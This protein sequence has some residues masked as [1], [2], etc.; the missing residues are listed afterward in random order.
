MT[1]GLTPWTDDVPLIGT[2]HLLPDPRYVE[3]IGRNHNLESAVADLIDNSVDAG[4]THVLVRIIRDSEMLRALC[5]V[6]DG[7]GINPNQM[8]RAMTIGARRD[9]LHGDLGYFGIGMKAA[10]LGQAEKLTVLSCSDEGVS[11]RVW[12]KERAA[13]DFECGVV[14]ES[15][16]DTEL[17]RDWSPVTSGTGTIVRWDGVRAFPS[18][19]D[20][21]V[22]DRVAENLVL[23]LRQHLGLTFHR[24]IVER[25]LTIAIDVEDVSSTE[26]PTTTEVAPIDPF[27]YASSPVAGYPRTLGGNIG[28]VPMTLECH[29]WST[30]SHLQGFR[31]P[32][33]RPTEFQ[34]FFF[35]RN[36]RLLQAG[37]WNHA[38]IN[39][40]K[41]QLARSVINLDDSLVSL[42]PPNP[43][44]TAITTPSGFADAVRSMT[45]SQGTTFADYLLSA[46]EAYT[47]SRRRSRTRRKVVPPGRG[48]APA[49]RRKIG[50]ELEFLPGEDQI[51]VVWGSL[52]DER[53]FDLDRDRRRVVLNRR[54]RWALVGDASGSLN[55]SP[56]V[57]ALLYLLIEQIFAGAHLG[58][59]DKDDIALFQAI[60]TTAA[61]LEIE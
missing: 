38:E 8:D 40:P 27:A 28:N 6:D 46:D 60:L 7:R 34:G 32:G 54:Y 5:V 2:T 53:F 58:P 15:F 22:A 25:S 35:Y 44:K 12:L 42:F 10:S 51:D 1:E 29:I 56:L 20:S 43:E 13:K 33:K 49:V 18:V 39:D 23:K 31:L 41:H 19:P 11:G 3:S 61:E 36:G 47:H 24:V 55:D 30:R 37:G 48:F 50:D 45:D 21:I 14:E 57:K 59:K 17:A 4:A 52:S 26:T 9:Y 16:A